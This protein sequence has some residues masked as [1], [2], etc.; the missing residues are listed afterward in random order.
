MRKNTSR[1]KKTSADLNFWAIDPTF[2][3][4]V[5]SF[6]AY[7]LWKFQADN[8][9]IAISDLAIWNSDAPSSEDRYEYNSE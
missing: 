5:V 2:L 8:L 3:Y 1:N 7:I 4:V 6:M 9:K